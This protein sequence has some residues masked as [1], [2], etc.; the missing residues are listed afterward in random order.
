MT[1]I[2][3]E[4]SKFPLEPT[5][6]KAL[7]YSHHSRRVQSDMLKLVSI[8]SSESIWLHAPKSEENPLKK[9]FDASSGD[10]Y[11]LV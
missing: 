6:A 11:F 7:L 9:K 2:G 3:H 1:D 8:L 10:H 4:I 5:Y